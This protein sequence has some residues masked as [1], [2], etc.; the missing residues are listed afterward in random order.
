MP[1]APYPNRLTDAEVLEARLHIDDPRETFDLLA[2]VPD[3]ARMAGIVAGYEHRQSKLRCARPGCGTLHNKGFVV[4]LDTGQHIII[5]HVCGKKV[6]HADWGTLEEEHHQLRER[7]RLLA[8]KQAFLGAYHENKIAI[9]SWRKHANAVQEAQRSFSSFMPKLTAALR[10]RCLHGQT[11]LTIT[12]KLD[13]RI[14]ET[15]RDAQAGMGRRATRQL[16]EREEAVHVL[17][18]RE[19][20]EAISPRDLIERALGILEESASKLILDNLPNHTMQRA[21]RE[22]GNALAD[23]RRFARIHAAARQAVSHEN[24]AG[25]V[26]WSQ[27]T[28]GYPMMEIQR[29]QIVCQHPGEQSHVFH[30]PTIEPLDDSPLGRLEGSP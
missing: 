9:R 7:Q 21:L 27:K 19:F 16:E 23:L 10:Q 18:G 26:R 1:E 14:A 2:Q 6:F 24:L 3:G 11:A 17:Q 12:V 5:G 13:R 29:G 4:Q 28:G 8:R 25:I 22:V 30:T 20:F 15:F